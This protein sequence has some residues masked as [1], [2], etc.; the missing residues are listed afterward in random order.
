MPD[1]A[2]LSSSAWRSSAASRAGS[3][4][5]TASS[6]TPGSTSNGKGASNTAHNH[7]NCL[8]S[9]SYYLDTPPG[10]GDILFRDPREVAYVYQPPYADGRSR[11]P[12][13]AIKPDPALLLLFPPWLLHWVEPNDSDSDR[14]SV[15]FNVGIGVRGG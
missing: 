4:T 1:W 14:I 15:A 3:W 6:S 5:V 12:D 2:A 7:P 13:T 8:L 11:T 10:C 9:G